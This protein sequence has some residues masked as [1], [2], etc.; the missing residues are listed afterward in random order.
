MGDLYQ[1]GA[2]VSRHF[3]YYAF[4]GGEGHNRWTH[5]GT[6]YHRDMGAMR[7]KLIP[8]INYRYCEVD[9]SHAADSTC[10]HRHLKHSLGGGN[11]F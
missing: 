11:S 2:D 7:K 3:S 1:N 6:D 5:E 4:E 10:Q 8:Q 9:T